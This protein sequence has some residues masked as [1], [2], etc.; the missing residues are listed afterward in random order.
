VIGGRYF[1]KFST[2]TIVMGLVMPILR[3]SAQAAEVSQ[4]LTLQVSFLVFQF[5]VGSDTQPE[6]K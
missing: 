2:P 4:I 3:S 1:G 6:E 5:M